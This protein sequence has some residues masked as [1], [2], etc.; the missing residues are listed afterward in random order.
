LV[1]LVL[2]T[3]L[4]WLVSMGSVGVV[5]LGIGAAGMGAASAATPDKSSSGDL[6]ETSDQIFASV[7]RQSTGAPARADIGDQ[8]TVRLSEDLVFVPQ[9][10]ASKLLI[11]TNIPVPP[12]FKAL[13]MC[14]EGIQAP[15]LI[16]FVPAGFVDS[17]AALAWTADDMLASLRDEVQRDNSDRVK[18]NLQPREARRWISAPRYNPETHQLS[19][20]ALIV[21]TSAPRETDGE[22]TFHAIG[23]GR[24]GYVELTV[25]TS[26]QKA[27]EIGH[28]VDGFLLG[29]NFR[30]GKAYGDALPTDRRAPGGLAKAM[31]IGSLHRAEAG[32]N[33][34]SGD[35][36]VPVAGGIVAAIGALSLLLYIRR[37]L[38]REARRG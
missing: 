26:M 31:G 38:R 33:L 25:A 16:R 34:M 23:F 22:I 32:G 6:L 10:P 12:D 24:E 29:L 15:G 7:L 3:L 1:R 5:G 11:V 35:T 27:E 37:H 19:W 14:S 2:V 4:S 30:P 28:M 8:A 21:P 36:M 20:A 17:D 13:L 18:I 9:E